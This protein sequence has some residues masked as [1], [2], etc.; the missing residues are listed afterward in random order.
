MIIRNLDLKR[1]MNIPIGKFCESTYCPD[2]DD[3]FTKDRY[4]NAAFSLLR[5]VSAR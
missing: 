4:C 1:P 5:L 2:K 3:N